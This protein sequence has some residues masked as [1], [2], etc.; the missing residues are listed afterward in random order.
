MNPSNWRF[1]HIFKENFIL[2]VLHVF[3]VC[4]KMGNLKTIFSYY[5]KKIGTL[6]LFFPSTKKTGN[7]STICIS[8]K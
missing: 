7:L 5:M 6:V 1:L 3:L 2:N 8:R 4:K